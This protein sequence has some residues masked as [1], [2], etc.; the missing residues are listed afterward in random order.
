M[1]LTS[2]WSTG[3]AQVSTGVAGSVTGWNSAVRA[4]YAPKPEF[5]FVSF[6]VFHNFTHFCMVPATCPYEWY[7]P[8]F[9]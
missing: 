8:Y 4:I 6:H 2:A 7:F 9:V 1:V 3:I 5:Y